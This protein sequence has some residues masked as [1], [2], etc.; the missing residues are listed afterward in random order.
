MNFDKSLW[1]RIS[2]DPLWY[3]SD[4]IWEII[5]KLFVN[6][7]SGIS[8][9]LRMFKHKVVDFVATRL[10]A[11]QVILGNREHFFND[12]DRWTTMEWWRL[13]LDTIVIHHTAT[14]S[15]LTYDQLN[16]L[17]LLRLYCPVYRNNKSFQIDGKLQP[18]SSG[19]LYQGHQTFVAYHWGIYDNENGVSIVRLLDDRYTG[20][21]AG[22]YPVNTRSVGIAF[23]G[24]LTNKSPSI[25]AIDAARG[26]IFRYPSIAKERVIGHKEVPGKESIVCP[27]NKWHEWKKLLIA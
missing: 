7:P 17:H 25:E 16:A 23:I 13:S 1:N 24:D 10:A 18:I 27:G 20:F 5:D 21:H 3:A 8:D 9:E 26:I 14:S 2:T 19:H 4:Q 15:H 22:N 6:P 11:G 12:D